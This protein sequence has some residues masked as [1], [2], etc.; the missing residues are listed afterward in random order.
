MAG[1]VA[2]LSDDDM[3]NIAYWLT[4]QKGK[5]GAATEK[6]LVSLGERIYRGG[7]AERNVPAWCRL[8]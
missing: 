1:F 7:I 2:M 6:E 4:T 3:R 5:P 8:P